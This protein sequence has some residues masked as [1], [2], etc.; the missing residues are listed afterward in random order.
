MKHC[1]KTEQNPGKAGKKKEKEKKK[2][3]NKLT[4]LN[5]YRDHSGIDLALNIVWLPEIATFEALSRTTRLSLD[6]DFGAAHLRL[7]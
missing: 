3:N 1:V 6:E 4:K 5:S 7:A 2:D